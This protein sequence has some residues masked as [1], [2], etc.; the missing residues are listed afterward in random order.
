MNC[1]LELQF[2]YRDWHQSSSRHGG[3]SI[4]TL[5]VKASRTPIQGHYLSWA[6]RHVSWP[7]VAVSLIATA[8]FSLAFQRVS[9]ITNMSDN[10][11]KHELMPH[12]NTTP[13]HSR[14]L[15][16][17]TPKPDLHTLPIDLIGCILVHGAEYI[18]IYGPG[19]VGELPAGLVSTPSTG[20]STTL[21]SGS[22]LCF[23]LPLSHR[24]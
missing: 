18:A 22:H 13:H 20:L 2:C 3:T 17:P 12:I 4:P 24:S 15:M 16:A 5:L 10:P 6:R 1:L 14:C 8:G 19:Y 11:K 23:D 7:Q 9:L 21:P